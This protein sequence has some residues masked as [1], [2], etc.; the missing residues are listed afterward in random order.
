VG[1]AGPTG[2]T[3]PT[4]ATG[5]TGPASGA[6]IISGGRSALTEF[7][8][9]NNPQL[10]GAPW[11]LGP[12]YTFA[13]VITDNPLPSH[14]GFLT[15][16]ADVQ[17][18]VKAAGTLSNFR[19]F[20]NAAPGPGASWTFTVRKNGANTGVSCPIVQP[21]TTCSSGATASFAVDDLL[22]IMVDP[23]FNPA[24][25]D[26]QTVIWRANYN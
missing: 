8:L 12:L 22:S 6:G 14:A 23:S 15:A 1:P 21:N 7:D 24:P 13:V 26:A 25:F 9:P 17:M 10:L 5:P 2:P 19:V 18:P 16:E 11:F 20:L 3:G 4:G